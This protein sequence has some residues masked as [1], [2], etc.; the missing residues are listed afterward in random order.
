ME[1][2]IIETERDDARVAYVGLGSR[3]VLDH[4]IGFFWGSFESVP[5][6]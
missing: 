6:L 4:G 5:D 3:G 1:I 2:N